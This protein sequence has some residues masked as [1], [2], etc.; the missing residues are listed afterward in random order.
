MPLTVSSS[1]HTLRQTA[2]AALGVLLA[3]IGIIGLI[4]PGLPGTMFVI[5]ASLLLAQSSPKLDRRLRRNRWLGPALQRLADSGGMTRESKALGLASTWA[6][7]AVGWFALAG[8][9]AGVLIAMGAIGAIATATI[10]LLPTA[11]GGDRGG[12]I[13]RRRFRMPAFGR[14]VREPGLLICVTAPPVAR[15]GRSLNLAYMNEGVA[16]V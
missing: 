5:A 12:V 15:A 13:S 7:L 16:G 14:V 8:L 9:G 10:W 6:E 1:R 11:Q 3:V 4:V 2:L